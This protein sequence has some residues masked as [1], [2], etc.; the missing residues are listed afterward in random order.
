M[1]LANSAS[2]TNKGA[3]NNSHTVSE[4][5]AL[6]EELHKPMKKK[7]ENDIGC[8]SFID[9]IWCADIADTIYVFSKYA[10]VTFL[11]DK[12]VL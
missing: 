3:W 5:Y 1:L 7:I 11:K 2:N 6:Y 12:K 8:S 9:N 10:C 4:N